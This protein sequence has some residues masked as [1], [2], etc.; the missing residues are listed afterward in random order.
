M[1]AGS[2]RSFQ[3][4]VPR[5]FSRYSYLLQSVLAIAAFHLAY[6]HPEEASK[7]ILAGTKH[8]EKATSGYRDALE[9]GPSTEE[10]HAV[11]AQ[12]LLLYMLSLAASAHPR[13]LAPD[14][15]PELNDVLE[16]FMLLRGT[17]KVCMSLDRAVRTGPFADIFPG[18][19]LHERAELPEP[20]LAHIDALRKTVAKAVA[21]K[22]AELH[23]TSALDALQFII[24]EVACGKEGNPNQGLV[25]KWAYLVSR[26]YVGYL[27]NHEPAAL[28]IFAHFAAVSKLEPTTWYF[29]G[30]PERAVQAVS[31]V[32]SPE[33]KYW[34]EWPLKRL[35]SDLTE[36]R[37]HQLPSVEL[38]L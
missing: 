37:H 16:P 9:A 33:W 35:E 27:R 7:W 11:L 1:T 15:V 36:S 25:S 21:G 22:P 34:V 3:E 24:G 26:H 32:L 14:N 19:F 31:S 8:H 28:V 5:Q 17:G 20:A 2:Q 29:E 10:C 12:A 13:L 6:L 18:H 4:W 30:W 38:N 23:L